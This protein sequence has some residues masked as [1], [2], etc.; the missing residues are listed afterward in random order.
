MGGGGWRASR[1]VGVRGV[2]L[3]GGYDAPAAS[4]GATTVRV[5]LQ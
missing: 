1:G 5:G 3:Q 2:V 4:G